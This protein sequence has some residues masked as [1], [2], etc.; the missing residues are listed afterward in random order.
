MPPHPPHCRSTLLIATRPPPAQLDADTRTPDDCDALGHLARE[1]YH[2]PKL[3][4]LQC[5]MKGFVDDL[6]TA[7]AF[8]KMQLHWT[9]GLFYEAI[10]L[11]C[12]GGCPPPI[13]G[14]NVALR[15]AAMLEVAAM[16]EKVQGKAAFGG[17]HF[18]SELHTGEDFVMMMKIMQSSY[19]HVAY[20]TYMEGWAEG[21]DENVHVNWTNYKK[22]VNST[23]EMVFNPP[24]LWFALPCECNREEGEQPGIFT[25]LIKEYL[26]NTP[27]CPWYAKVATL[28]YLG[29][30]LAF[31]LSLP[32]VWLAVLW[33]REL[34]VRPYVLSSLDIYVT[35]LIVFTGFGS[36]AQQVIKRRHLRH[37]KIGPHLAAINK[38]ATGQ[39][40]LMRGGWPN[41]AALWVEMVVYGGMKLFLFGG[42][43]VHT[44][45]IVGAY[46]LE[47]APDY[48]ASRLS[49]AA[50][51]PR[52]ALQAASN[53]ICGTRTGEDV[54]KE[55]KSQTCVG[56][57]VRRV[58][59]G[60]PI[61]EEEQ[62]EMVAEL[63]GG[64]AKQ[65]AVLLA[66]SFLHLLLWWAGIIPVAWEVLP[67]VSFHVFGLS[68]PLFLDETFRSN[69]RLWADERVDKLA[70]K[71][72]SWNFPI[73]SG[74]PDTRNERAA[75]RA[76]WQ[77][78]TSEAHGL[79][80]IG[81]ALDLME[82]G[83]QAASA[84]ASDGG[85]EKPYAPGE[86]AAGKASIF[87][88][89]QVTPQPWSHGADEAPVAATGHTPGSVQVPPWH[90]E[91]AR[92][93]SE[94]E[95]LAAVLEQ[96]ITAPTTAI[97]RAR[98]ARNTAR[99]EHNLSPLAGE[100]A[101]DWL[102]QREESEGGL[103]PYQLRHGSIME[104]L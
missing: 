22:Y 19:P 64:Y 99:R 71:F 63:E 24:R 61:P 3:G 67:L 96:E 81:R 30:H 29:T 104:R 59:C 45:F 74:Q 36:P 34:R 54:R 48:G 4:A 70:M 100:V 25:P 32:L 95:L 44:S 50:A 33:L 38:E 83:E 42:L 11:A 91:A 68:A 17:R 21:V 80:G 31:G 89:H 26:F 49:S 7:T 65:Y 66:S 47:R 73:G 35:V 10:L 78:G 18:W 98:A 103:Q 46:L 77:P 43:G 6:E 12:A 2:D 20:L 16:L 8:Q 101:Q 97:E 41:L 52:N 55:T 62:E 72:E 51:V 79:L 92:P 86:K 57:L 28:G 69:T 84:A 5:A 39:H 87:R 85:C 23:M 82:R 58:V 94:A 102:L 88:R 14:H 27:A 76:G 90:S 40:W 75:R 1:F 13:V 37:T 53:I 93:R 56:R 15:G 60:K 9:A